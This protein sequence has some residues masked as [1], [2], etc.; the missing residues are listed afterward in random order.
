MR[1]G[2]AGST[3]HLLVRGSEPTVN[4]YNW[5]NVTGFLQ[6][7]RISPDPYG[8]WRPTFYFRGATIVMIISSSFFF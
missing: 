2:I 7:L 8:Q 6:L 1:E 4:H 3:V 5:V